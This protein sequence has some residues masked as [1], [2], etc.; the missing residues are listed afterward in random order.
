L[1]SPTTDQDR[2]GTPPAEARRADRSF[3]ALVAP[4]ITPFDAMSRTLTYA[5]ADVPSGIRFMAIGAFWFSIM[6]V[7]VKLAGRTV[8]SMDIVVYRG[9]VTILLSAWIMRRSR[10][11]PFWGI[12]KRL[13]VMRGVFGSLALMCFI[14]SLVHLPLGEATL[15]QYT[16]PIF[17]ILIAAFWYH[18]RIGRGEVLALVAALI[19][20]LLIARP[21]AIFGGARDAIHLGHAA[22]ALG[23]A[24]C[25]GA[26]Y[27]TIRRL[28]SENSH[29]V[30][31]YLPLL[32]IPIALPFV[33]GHWRMPSA[34][35]WAM[36]ISAGVATQLAQTYMTR[37]LQSERTAR[38]TTAGIL[39]V[40]F[41]AVWAVLI[42][43]ER[44][45]WLTIL[46]GVVIVGGASLLV[47]GRQTE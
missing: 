32:Q 41:A 31:F 27:A 42:F 43:G 11:Q 18:E 28:G 38:A 25:S 8:P 12:Q 22:I 5:V 47:L 46:G 26:A 14:F 45:T 1:N 9:L 17:A 4:L 24:A 16:N 6:S 15:I 19:G 7:L 33:V 20:V 40:V 30:V 29:V 23:G 36:L 34:V 10:V 35:E 3:R 39:Q 2:Q 21:A 13:L 37:G 44:F